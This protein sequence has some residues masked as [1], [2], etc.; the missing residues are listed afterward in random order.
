MVCADIIGTVISM[1]AMQLDL[2]PAEIISAVCAEK[3]PETQSVTAIQEALLP[4]E[5]MWE[6]CAERKVRVQ[7]TTAISLIRLDRIME[8]VSLS[9]MLK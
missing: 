7:S 4:V 6:V 1:T 3:T 9:Q 2:L 8:T 5:I